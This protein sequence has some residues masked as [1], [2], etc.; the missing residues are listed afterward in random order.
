MALC[1]KDSDCTLYI[2]AAIHCNLGNRRKDSLSGS[3]KTE[4]RDIFAQKVL[5]G[6]MLCIVCQAA[7]D[8]VVMLCL[9]GCNH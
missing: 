1:S 7:K 2:S 9:A 3:T 4:L 5:T 6:N 8:D